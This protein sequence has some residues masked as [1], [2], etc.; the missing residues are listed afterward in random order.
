MG[1]EVDLSGLEQREKN[2]EKL[3]GTHEVKGEDLLPDDFIRQN[4]N[5]QT[6][7]AFLEASGIKSQ[8]DMSTDAFDNFVAANTR[9]A[10]WQEMFKAAGTEWGKR[11][12]FA[13]LE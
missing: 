6:R 5:F 1:V 4:T 7:S 2:L 10:N 8:E 12:L 13:G 11:Q 9:F 3:G